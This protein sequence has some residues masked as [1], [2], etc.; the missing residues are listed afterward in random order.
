MSKISCGTDIIEISRIEKAIL[1]NGRFT[2]RV[3][4][5]GEMEYFQSHGSR[6]ET[7]AGFFAAKEA[8]SKFLGTGIRGFELCDIEV[9]HSDLGAPCIVFKGKKTDVSLS[10]SH[11]DSTAVAVVCG[12]LPDGAMYKADMEYHKKMKELIPQ[13]AEDANK[14]S[15]G[16]AFI[17]AGSKGMTGAA[18]LCGYG[19]LRS[20]CGL[21]TVGTAESEQGIVACKLTEAMTVALPCRDGIICRNS[22]DLIKEYAKKADVV[23]IGPGL[24]RG[25]GISEVVAELVR[26]YKKTLIIDADG[27]NA[28]SGNIDILKEKCGEIILTPHPGEMSRLCGASVEKIQGSREEIAAE[29]AAKYDVCLVLKGKNTVI[30]SGDGQISINPTGNSG[31]ATGG[32]GD[33]LCGV[34]AALAAQGLSAYD[35]AVLG[36]YLHGL[37]GDI[38]AEEKGIHGLIASDVAEALPKSL[39]ELC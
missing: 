38:A 2:E 24:G 36:V 7:L 3:F 33:V 28:L 23:A 14:G 12:E 11:N 30:A 37:A 10:I 13:R 4:T 27:I 15:C 21:V 17:I 8:F 26:S 19:A 1:K 39:K 25:D 9:G 35:S 18:A 16:R 20:G 6:T 22:I 31:M 29:F 32:T 5:K 34:V